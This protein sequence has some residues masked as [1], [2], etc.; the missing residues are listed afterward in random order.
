MFASVGKAKLGPCGV[1]CLNG[2]SCCVLN[3]QKTQLNLNLLFMFRGVS[4]LK[5]KPHYPA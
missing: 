4:Q 5:E 2:N 3:F 1:C